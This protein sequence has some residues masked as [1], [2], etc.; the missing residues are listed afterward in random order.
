MEVFNKLTEGEL[1]FN[2]S[3]VI[4]RHVKKPHPFGIFYG[5]NPLN[6]GFP[7]LLLDIT[8]M[9]AMTRTIR[10]LLKPLRQPRVVSQI[11]GGIIMGSSVLGKSKSFRSYL[12]TDNANYVFKNIGILGFM[13]FLFVSGVKT[14]LNVVKNVGRKHWCIASV[15]VFVPLICTLSTAI[16]QRNMMEENIARPSSIW[17]FSSSFA[18]TAFPVIHPII[19]ELNLYSSEIGRLALS[20]AV[21][22]DVI[23]INTI[24]AFEAAKQAEGKH[25]AVLWYMIS[26]VIFMASIFGG[27]RLA[28]LWIVRTTPEGKPVEQIYVVAILLSVVIVGFLSDMLGIAIANGSLCLGLAVPDGP[29]LGATIVEKSETVMMDILMPFSFLFVGLIVDVSSLGSKWSVLQP[30]FI[31]AIVAYVTK[32]V[33]TLMACR[34]LNMPLKEC[35]AV[36]LILSLRGEVEILLFIHWMDFQIITVPYFT[37]MVLT[38]TCV[39]AIATPLISLLYDPTRPYMVNKRRNIQ[40]NPPNTE[41]GIVACI[42]DE[43]NVTGIINLLEVSNPSTGSPFHVYALQV[44]DIIARATPVFIDHEKEEKEC[45]QASYSSIHRALKLFEEA[46]GD[47]ITVQLYTSITTRRSMYQDICELALL[48]KASLIILP[49]DKEIIISTGTEGVRKRVQSINTDVLKHAPC[50]VAILVDRD[51]SPKNLI[52]VSM[53]R[54]IRYVLVLFL[55]GADAREALSFADRMAG[56]ATVSLTVIRF[57]SHNDEGDDKM[58]KK[59][60]D[61]QVTWFWVKNEGNERV[62]YREVTVQNGEETA[63]AVR[64]LSSDDYDLLIMGRKDGINPVL[65]QGLS[66]WSEN[67]E[68]GVIGDYIASSDIWS[69]ASALVMQQQQLRG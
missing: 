65:L 48:K 27:F 19:K 14:D 7:T 17:G 49:F 57:L 24:L 6:F 55:G 33:A 12:F 22:T 34:F 36:S 18:L 60:D 42:H 5:D 38:T 41:L 35:V 13:Y 20:T 67:H 28:M 32:M 39:T 47:Y 21:V 30:V 8:L 69:R 64:A 37:M 56:N 63:A 61:G 44:I 23:G 45:D 26:L 16:P 51:P 59:L 52:H 62:T 10:F 66:N 53:S 54:S 29:P 15:S 58:E 3:L 46:R 40:H 2:H 4:C 9:V 1:L 43:K 31:M 25:I 50:S 11:L 68:L